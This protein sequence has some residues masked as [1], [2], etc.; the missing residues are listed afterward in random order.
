MRP[1]TEYDLLRQRHKLTA[2]QD[3]DFTVRNL[4]EIAETA[5]IQSI[6][7]GL[8]QTS[9]HVSL[10]VGGIGIMNIMLVAVSSDSN[11]IG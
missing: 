7:T 2:M 1:G 9:Q 8:P 4:G 10:L 11:G 3:N 5:S 6:M